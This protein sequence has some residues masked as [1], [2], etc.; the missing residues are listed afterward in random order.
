VG[1]ILINLL[2]PAMINTKNNSS[3][4]KAQASTELLVVLIIAFAV[5]L[6]FLHYNR[7]KFLISTIHCVKRKSSWL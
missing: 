7:E 4:A 5:V 2:T 3:E 1:G 6:I